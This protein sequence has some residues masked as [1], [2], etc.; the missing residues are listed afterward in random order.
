MTIRVA[1]IDAPEKCQPSGDRSTRL[2][3]DLV[4]GK[5]VS[6]AV[7][8]KDKFGRTLA[9]VQTMNGIDV[10]RSML[11]AGAAWVFKSPRLPPENEQAEANARRFRV[12]LWGQP[13]AVPPWEWRQ[14]NARS[15]S[16]CTEARPVAEAPE[17]AFP[18]AVSHNNREVEEAL[19]RLEQRSRAETAASSLSSIPYTAP[20]VGT[21]SGAPTIHTGPKGGRYYI[22]GGGNKEY[23]PRN[24]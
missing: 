3:Q 1:H 5:R 18:P 13:N 8:G 23:V 24:R 20:P 21:G 15:M 22:N 19:S 9:S 10:S 12:G 11:D 2:L 14:G 6:L 17:K 7:I 4:L 16:T